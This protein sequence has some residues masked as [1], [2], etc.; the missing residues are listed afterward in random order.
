MYKY[1]KYI[2]FLT[3]ATNEHGIHSPFIFNF[4]TQCLYNKSLKINI[5]LPDHFVKPQSINRKK[6]VL[7]LKL[8]NYF[9]SES[10]N[11]ILTNEKELPLKK[12]K[13]DMIYIREP[14]YY[15][16]SLVDQSIHNNSVVIIGHIHE[17]RKNYEIWKQLITYSGITASVNIFSL[18]VLFFRKEQ[19]KEH[20]NIRV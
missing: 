13:A 2:Q 10:K 20:F 12:E 17:S 3:L 4:T 14:Q 15:V 19:A 11:F 1:L 9:C 16:Q 6:K 7:L 8:V 5:Q 18:G